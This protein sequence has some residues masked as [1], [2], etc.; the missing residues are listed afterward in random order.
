MQIFL[1]FFAKNLLIQDRGVGAGE[2]I[3]NIPSPV[4]ALHYDGLNRCLLV[5]VASLH[6]GEEARHSVIGEVR[7]VFHQPLG[8]PQ[9]G[10]LVALDDNVLEGGSVSVHN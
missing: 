4:R 2:L 3:D 9:E 5:L 7:G 10:G 6:E 1:D 8:Y